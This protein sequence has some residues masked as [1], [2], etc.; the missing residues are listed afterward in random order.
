MRR[1]A[2][3]VG[4]VL[5]G[6]AVTLFVLFSQTEVTRTLRQ[7][8]PVYVLVVLVDEE[9]PGG[10]QAEV[11]AV[12]AFQPG[13]KATWISVPRHLAWPTAAGWTSLHA[14]YATEGIAGLVRRLTLLLE[15]PLSYWWVV[16]FAGFPKIVDAVG[17]VEVTVEERLVYQDRSRNLF[18]DIP[19]GKQT[20]DGATALD[21]VRYRDDDESRR[22]ERQHQFLRALLDRAQALPPARWRTTAEEVRAAARTN[23]SLWEVLDL[24][25]GLGDPAPDRT[26]FV[27]VPALPRAGGDGQLV[28]DLVRL[29]K[30]TQSL[31]RPQAFL[32][33]DEIR[34]L[35]LNGAGVKLLATR[36]GAWLADLG[37]SVV[38]MGDADRS[39]YPRTY[40]V[41][42][43]EARAKGR[44]LLEALPSA[45]QP[46]V[47]IQTDREFDL[48]RVGGWPENTDLILILGAG[49][50]VRP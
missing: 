28:P 1:V 43:E 8:S 20:L 36:T 31:V 7:G 12:A 50:D 39:N 11:V 23:L 46:G 6:V 5:I 21:F 27:A 3:G 4:L 32:T 49:F 14:L 29:R 9:A 13:G 42:R 15:V 16:D 30:L 45:V 47:Q 38:G 24:A 33:R 41:V 35:V 17:G 34:V 25:K 18:I 19:P 2:I 26:T 40:I 10:A 22:M 48:G 44:A 37:F